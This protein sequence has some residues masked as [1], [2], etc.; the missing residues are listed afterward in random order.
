[1]TYIENDT[2]RYE[3]MSK[4]DRKRNPPRTSRRNIEKARNGTAQQD[5]ILDPPPFARSLL[6][7]KKVFELFVSFLTH[8][9]R[10]GRHRSRTL[11]N[12]AAPGFLGGLGH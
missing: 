8:F 11:R 9:V 6:H 12:Q 4:N 1:M 3:H 7:Q 5:T 10:C 2:T